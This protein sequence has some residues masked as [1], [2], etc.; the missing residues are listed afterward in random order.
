MAP[1][2]A[3]ALPT[4]LKALTSP[5]V[6]GTAAAW[7]GEKLGLSD[8]TVEAVTNVIN[9]LGPEEQIKMQ[10]LDKQFKQF[11]IAQ[12]N[13]I[14]LAELGLLQGQLE[15]NKEEAKS[16]ILFVSGW[17]PY[18]GWGCGTA[19]LYAG[20]FEPL[21]RFVAQVIFEYKG[22]FPVLD[23]GLTVTVLLGMLGIAG[24]R[25]YEKKEGVAEDGLKR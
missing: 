16:S 9:G 3:A 13:Q 21:L 14:H 1:L 20:L 8:N 7:V 12:E 10:Q 23:T 15:V 22:E 4:L 5:V 19:F 11:V 18:V 24:M 2:I 25:T 6:A 17:R